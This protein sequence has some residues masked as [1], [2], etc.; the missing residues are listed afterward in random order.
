MTMAIRIIPRPSASGRSPLLVSSAMV[1]VITR[2][3]PSMFPPTII[4]APTSAAARP[5]PARIVVSSENRVSHRSVRAASARPAPSERSCSSYSRQASSIAWR[6]SA[7]MIGRISTVCAITIAEGVNRI[8]R[9]PSGPARERRRYTTRPTTTGGSPMNAFRNTISVRRPGNRPT[10][11]A[12]PSGKPRSAAMPTA[13]RL[14]LRLSRTISTSLGSK[15][16]SKDKAVVSASVMRMRGFDPSVIYVLNYIL[17]I[18]FKLYHSVL[19]IYDLDSHYANRIRTRLET[20]L[21]AGSSLA[22]AAPH[23]DTA[24]RLAGSGSARRRLLVSPRMESPRGLERAHG[25]AARR[26]GTRAGCPPHAPR[27]EAP[28]AGRA[29]TRQARASAGGARS[30]VRARALRRSHRP[31]AAPQYLRKPRHGAGADA[32]AD[33]RH[34]PA[35]TAV[36]R[37][38]GKPGGAGPRGVR[39]RRVPR[40]RAVADAGDRG[41]ARPEG[42]QGDRTRRARPG[43]DR[44]ARQS[45]GHPRSTRPRSLRGAIRQ[46]TAGVRDSAG[47]RSTDRPG[48]NRGRRVGRLLARGVHAHGGCG[49]RS[50]RQRRRRFRHSGGGG[51]AGAG[52]H[53]AGERALPSC[54]PV[55]P[56][57][58]RR[59]EEISGAA[60]RQ[61]VQGG[62]GVLAGIRQRDYWPRHGSCGRALPTPSGANHGAGLGQAPPLRRSSDTALTRAKTSSPWARPSCPAARAVILERSLAAPTVMV[63]STTPLRSSPIAATVPF[64]T[65]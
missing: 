48:R 40:R 15:V 33:R 22:R 36:S 56:A 64:S 37:Q 41:A 46:S 19:A 51:A 1:V 12:A 34:A 23:R 10:A 20:P 13:V 6:E 25:P 50:E 49:G 8:P 62:A 59:C 45:H 57:G 17:R 44:R 11:R 63:T 39:P 26:A 58:K 27:A 38:R 29:R 21:G 3:T 28:G 35:G 9:E 54:L 14:T 31:G 2:V 16:T 30:G 52:I 42:A 43:S 7:A 4:P 32:G 24:L 61:A 5:N 55:G 65:F 18:L 60:S 53:T 47:I